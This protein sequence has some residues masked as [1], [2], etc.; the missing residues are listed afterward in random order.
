VVLLI[1]F[2]VGRALAF[3]QLLPAAVDEQAEMAELGGFPVEGLVQLGVFWCGNKPLLGKGGI[4]SAKFGQGRDHGLTAPR[5][6]WV[7]FMWWS[8]TT[9]AK[10]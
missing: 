5:M 2:D 3:A 4:Q 1:K 7:I 10:W 9:L 6:T 8:S